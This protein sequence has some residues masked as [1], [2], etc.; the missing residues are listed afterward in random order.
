MMAFRVAFMMG[1]TW[2]GMALG[3]S[4]DV[5]RM[6]FMMGYDDGRMVSGVRV[7]LGWR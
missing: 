5:V 6:A 3:W 7:A 1:Y 4:L 2:A